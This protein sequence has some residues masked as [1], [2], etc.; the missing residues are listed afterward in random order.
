MANSPENGYFPQKTAINYE[1]V[2]KR[3]NRRDHQ[4]SC[5]QGTKKEACFYLTPKAKLV[6]TT[7]VEP[8]QPAFLQAYV[9][10]IYMHI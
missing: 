3:W 9:A 4:K 6:P 8:V 10:F 5:S 7:G 1:N 2:K